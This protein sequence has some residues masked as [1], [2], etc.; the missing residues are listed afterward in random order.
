MDTIV[1][2]ATEIGARRIFPVISERSQV[3]LEQDRSDRKVEKWRTTALEA[4]KQCGNPWLPDIAPVTSLAEQLTPLATDAVGLVAALTAGTRTIRQALAS[5]ARGTA[6]RVT[7]MIGPEGDFSPEEVEA[8]QRCGF[9]PISLGPL[10]LR[11]DTAAA[12]ALSVI[13]HELQHWDR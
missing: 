7:V 3:Q 10:V 6:P 13:S 4:C 1:R 2:E 12:Y 8:A 11:C 5:A 9:L